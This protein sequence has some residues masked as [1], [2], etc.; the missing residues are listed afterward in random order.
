VNVEVKEGNQF[1]SR[2]NAQPFATGSLSMRSR[3]LACMAKTTKFKTQE[4]KYT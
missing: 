2:Y 4:T 3:R 1:L